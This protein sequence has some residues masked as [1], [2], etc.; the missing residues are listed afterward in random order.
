VFEK[1]K[2][3]LEDKEVFVLDAFVGATHPEHRIPVRVITFV[4]ACLAQ[5]VSSDTMLLPAK[6]G[7]VRPHHRPV[8][9]HRSARPS[10]PPKD[11][12]GTNGPNRD[13]GGLPEETDADRHQPSNAGE[14]KKSA[15]SLMNFV[16]PQKGT[17][18]MHGQREHRPAGRHGG[19]LRTV[20]DGQDD[21]LGRFPADADRR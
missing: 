15:F 8:H 20:R 5:P 10:R 6:A 12:D 1:M 4:P 13:P 17:M 11:E 21:A 19:V 9:D 2:R 14:M 7:R 3:F 18:P 16:L